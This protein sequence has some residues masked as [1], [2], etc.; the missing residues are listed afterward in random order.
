MVLWQ[1]HG[2]TYLK[3][4]YKRQN[5]V[6]PL[7]K[8]KTRTDVDFVFFIICKV[9]SKGSYLHAIVEACLKEMTFYYKFNSRKSPAFLFLVLSSTD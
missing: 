8:L 7:Y 1:K 5:N 6:Q 4:H 3:K 9:C 2:D